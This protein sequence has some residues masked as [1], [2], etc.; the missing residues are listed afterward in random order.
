MTKFNAFRIHSTAGKVHAGF[1]SIEL[2]D[3]SDGDVLIKSIYSSINYKD[4]LA[5]TGKGRILRQF[6]LVG[7][8]DVAGTVES[9][10]DPRFS[11]GDEVLVCG[12]GLSETRDGGY[13][14]FVR[15]PA[16]S[17]ISLPQ[18][19]TLFQAMAISTAGFTAAYAVNQLQLNGQNPEK[20][21]I[22]VS[23]AT[24][25][26]GSYAI[27]LLSGLDFEVIAISRKQQQTAYLKS[28]GAA[29]VLLADELLMGKKP[30]EKAVWG[31]AVD[32]VGGQLLSWL[33]RTVKPFGNI[34]V[35]GLTGGIELETTVMPFLLR[36]I[37]L[38][39]IHSVNCPIKLKAHIWQRLATD[40]KPQHIDKIVTSEI[41][42]SQLSDMFEAYLL[43]EV[44]G[45]TVVKISDN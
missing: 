9:S 39:G 26:V 16:D 11:K 17:V 27:D 13:A 5:A 18:G 8:I 33:T 44:S 38:L 34:T 20:G 36:G 10:T 32:C 42:F 35:I 40:M 37:N 1:E 24:G 22:I 21:P 6:P 41:A 19:L 2:N 29:Q 28:L 3:L 25:G 45:R 43:G 23:G 4:A 15:V 31:G 7:G 12:E 14:E 30:L